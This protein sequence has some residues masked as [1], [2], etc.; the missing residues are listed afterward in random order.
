MSVYLGDSG[1]IELQRT[2]LNTP[3]SS[4]LDPADVN[5]TRKRFSFDFPA[6]SL[7]TGD[8]LSIGTQDNTQLT[9]VAGHTGE[10]GLWYIH[11]DGA[12]GVR[13]YDSFSAAINGEESNA[14][15]LA[16]AAGPQA[17]WAT[18]SEN[19]WRALAQVRD[20]T[21]PTN[22]DSVDLTAIGEEFRRN[23]ADGLIGG[24]G[25]FTC[26]WDY[27]A[28]QCCDPSTDIQYSHY[29]AQ[30]ILRTQLGAAFAGRFYVKTP[31]SAPLENC[32][33]PGQLDDAI[34]WEATCVITNVSFDFSPTQ[35]IS[36][37]INFV[38]TGEA[39]CPAISCRMAAMD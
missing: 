1:L 16:V 36:S 3:L 12:G 27:E 11:V 22:R 5:V 19:R 31:N 2:W 18:T 20:Y 33:N 15:S 38:T 35:M 29:L 13:L 7:I 14:L 32:L 30:L 17:I 25:S 10:D 26:F 28:S 9:L 37:Q 4:V 24:Q 8:R 21:F 39:W 23:Y 34:W 6:T